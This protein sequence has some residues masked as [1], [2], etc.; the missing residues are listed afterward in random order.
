MTAKRWN[1]FSASQK[2]ADCCRADY[3]C[4][5]VVF[6]KES[7]HRQRNSGDNYRYDEPSPGFHCL[8][9]LV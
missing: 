9:F 7:E 1:L 8:Y 6:E 5:N 2:S 3:S 4:R